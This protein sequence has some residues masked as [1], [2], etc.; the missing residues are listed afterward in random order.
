MEIEFEKGDAVAIDGVKMSPA[1]LLTKLNTLGGANGIGRIDLVESRFVG[2]KSRGVY[3]TP[4]GTIL[5]MAHRGIESI[6][7]DR[8]E[9]HLKVQH[10]LRLA[11]CDL[12][13]FL[14]PLACAA[15]ACW[16][17]GELPCRYLMQHIQAASSSCMSAALVRSCF[18]MR[19]VCL[20]VVPR[21]LLLP[22]PC[23]CTL[24]PAHT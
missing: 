24:P 2:M 10:G 13:A 6:T 7:L 4:G 19:V 22:E 18:A 21:L 20:K 15:A 17:A 11:C 23:T 1:T 12:A 9:A 16:W 14:L 8:A 5:L 3:E